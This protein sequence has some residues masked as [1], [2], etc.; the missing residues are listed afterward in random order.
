VQIIIYAVYSVTSCRLWLNYRCS[1]T[2]QF[3]RGR[4][5]FR[6]H[7]AAGPDSPH[8]RPRQNKRCT[9]VV[10]SRKL[11]YMLSEQFNSRLLATQFFLPVNSCTVPHNV[12]QC[13]YVYATFF[14]NH[15]CQSAIN[16]IQIV[17]PCGSKLTYCKRLIA[18]SIL[19]D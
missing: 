9:V 8:R 11:R 3:C 18:K 19:S 6:S 15:V 12:L 1:N 10:A 16:K 13:L 14:P 7:S 4:L 2:K 17:A 5:P